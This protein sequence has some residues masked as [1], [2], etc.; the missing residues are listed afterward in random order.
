MM[1]LFTIAC[2]FA[3]HSTLL[4]LLL[5]YAIEATSGTQPFLAFI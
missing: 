3:F 5:P 1:G 2:R 4:V